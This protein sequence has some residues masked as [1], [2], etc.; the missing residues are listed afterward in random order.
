M[1]KRCAWMVFILLLLG[2][3][4]GGSLELFCRLESRISISLKNCRI[5]FLIIGG[6]LFIVNSFVFIKNIV[7]SFMLITIALF[8]FVGFISVQKF[9]K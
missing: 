6:T 4:I 1:I 2:S 7:Y 3:F 5:I 8:V 9:L